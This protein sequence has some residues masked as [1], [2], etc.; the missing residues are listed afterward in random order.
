[1]A[2]G[3]DWELRDKIATT[4][5]VELRKLGSWTIVK[6]I[7]IVFDFVHTILSR[8]VLVVLEPWL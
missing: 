8:H 5:L 7:N 6:M 4:L 3:K 2:T 1:M